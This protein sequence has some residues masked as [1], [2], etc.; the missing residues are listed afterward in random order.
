MRSWGKH[1]D[2]YGYIVM[3]PWKV[4]DLQLLLVKLNV[5][6]INKKWH[7]FQKF[8][9]TTTQKQHSALWNNGFETVKCDTNV[10]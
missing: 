10:R 2:K 3:W 6:Q 8:N 9:K 7:I 4:V 1:F 5:Q